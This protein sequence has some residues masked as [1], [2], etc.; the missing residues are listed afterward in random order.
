MST[1]GGGRGRGPNVPRYPGVR[2]YR[3]DYRRDRPD[4]RRSNR[5]NNDDDG[6]NYGGN[7]YGGNDFYSGFG[8]ISLVLCSLQHFLFPF[9]AVLLKL[10][11]IF[12]LSKIS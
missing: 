2:M 9:Q 6:D 4:D 11:A 7:S 3:D 5:Y 12:L 8:L 10:K 1:R